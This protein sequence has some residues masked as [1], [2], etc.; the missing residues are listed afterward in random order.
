MFFIS[1]ERL[2]ALESQVVYISVQS[3]KIVFEN[4][5]LSLRD[6]DY[7]AKC[8]ITAGSIGHP[9]KLEVVQVGDAFTYILRDEN[10][11]EIRVQ[12]VSPVSKKVGLLVS[13]V[14]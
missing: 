14:A 2:V 12:D 7:D 5:H 9:S 3:T 13:K 11:F 6:I 4:L 1:K 8:T 10:T